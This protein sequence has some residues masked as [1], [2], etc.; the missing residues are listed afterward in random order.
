MRERVRSI[1]GRLSIENRGR[2][3]GVAIRALLSPEPKA[4]AA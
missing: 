1:G 4:V 2:S 3:R